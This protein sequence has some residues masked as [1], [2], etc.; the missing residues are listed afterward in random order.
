[1][2]ATSKR[3]KAVQLLACRA[4]LAKHLQGEALERALLDLRDTMR[5]GPQ[6]WAFKPAADTQPTSGEPT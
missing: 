1:M 4:A 6:A 2:S 5:K 3:R